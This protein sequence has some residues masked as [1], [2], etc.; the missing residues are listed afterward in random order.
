MKAN[1][2][3]RNDGKPQALAASKHLKDEKV[4]N[5]E[6]GFNELLGGALN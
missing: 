1:S 4:A 2:Q 6:S 3:K 5:C